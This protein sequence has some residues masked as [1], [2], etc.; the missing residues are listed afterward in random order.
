M[1]FQNKRGTQTLSLFG[2]NIPTT[3][4]APFE[5]YEVDLETHI[6]NKYNISPSFNQPK[7]TKPICA[8]DSK[9]GE[10]NV[11][12]FSGLAPMQRINSGVRLCPPD[13]TAFSTETCA[14]RHLKQIDNAKLVGRKNFSVSYAPEFIIISGG[15]DS[16]SRQLSDFMRYSLLDGEWFYLK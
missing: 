2:G 6:W 11:Y 16:K 5:A 13:L 8:V 4:S 12:Q 9:S 1:V 7:G 15:M 3:G 10:V 14:Q